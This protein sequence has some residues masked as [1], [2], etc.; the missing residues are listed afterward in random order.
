MKYYFY[1]F[2]S[3]LLLPLAGQAQQATPKAFTLEEAIAYALENSVNAK[4]AKL[5]EEISKAKV[6]EIT[7]IGL[8]QI[9]GSATVLH[10]Q[11][12]G[13]FFAQYKGPEGFLGDLSGVPG[14]EEGDVVAAKN[15]FQLPS[16]GQA[17]IS[18]TQLLFN[19]SY[20][21]G[22]KAS[23]TY[24]DL[25]EKQSELTRQ[26]IIENVS[27]AYYGVIIN[28]ERINLFDANIARVDSLFRSTKAFNEN[29]FA[30]SI[31]VDRTEVT[32]NNLK[33]ERDKFISIQEL[34]LNLLK[35]QM[36]YPLEMDIAVAGTIEDLRVDRDISSLAKDWDYTTRIEYSILE[37][38]RDLQDLNIKSKYSEGMPSLVAFADF[39]M[40]TQS[41]NVSGIFKTNSSFE[42]NS[43]LGRDKWYPTSSFGVSL[44][45]PIFSGLQRNYRIQQ[46][47][48]TA[49]K[50]ENSFTSLKQGISLEI[51][52]GTLTYENALR[53]LDA[54][55]RNMEL[56]DKIARVTKVKYEQGVGSSLEVTDAESALREAQIN[57]YNALYDALISRIDLVK[58]YGKINTITETFKK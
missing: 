3:V 5:D 15:P 26:Q 51:K 58:A 38:N 10:N 12:L 23:R 35:F 28:S 52:Q 8:P 4:N 24:K 25:S 9:D 53:S 40:N 22:L 47:K 2:I 30:E 14:L 32:L 16:N 34:G 41:P 11:Q 42:E 49:L 7:G 33:A 36:N 1:L 48:L 45:I 20:L 57:Y 55:N 43:Q 29:G 18:V 27:K 17:G 19:T 21:V 50:I 37:T 13:R 39:G 6:R 54:Q 46:E 31:D 44:N 56:A